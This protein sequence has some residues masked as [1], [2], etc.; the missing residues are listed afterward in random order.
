MS[1]IP[2]DKMDRKTLQREARDINREIGPLQRELYDLEK[3]DPENDR[4]GVIRSELEPHW[5][6]LRSLRKRRNELIKEEE[7]QRHQE[8][9]SKKA[10]TLSWMEKK[11]AMEKACVEFAESASKQA[12]ALSQDVD[13]RDL[14]VR[15]KAL[16]R[17]SLAA[18]E[19]FRRAN[20]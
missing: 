16:E 5:V 7:N 13:K 14:Y 11:Q 2:I 10:M 20:I 12:E 18:A 17:G 15:F 3:E 8:E 4:V 6:R 1:E 9:M 19:I